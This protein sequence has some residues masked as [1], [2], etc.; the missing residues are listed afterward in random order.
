MDNISSSKN[1]K[2]N[3]LMQ[4][5]LVNISIPNINLIKPIFKEPTQE[6]LK[7]KL[8]PKLTQVWQKWSKQD[9]LADQQLLELIQNENINLHA[10]D[11]VLLSFAVE[12]RPD[13]ALFLI[14]NGANYNAR[15]GAIINKAIKLDRVELLVAIMN[16][17][18]S[19]YLQRQDI[20]DKIKNHNSFSDTLIKLTFQDRVS[21]RNNKE[22]T[23]LY[24]AIDSIKHIIEEMNKNNNLSFFQPIY[25]EI[26]KNFPTN[27]KKIIDDIIFSHYTKTLE[28]NEKKLI[29]SKLIHNSEDIS[30]SFTESLTNN[31]SIETLQKNE[32]KKP[33][34]EIK[35][36]TFETKH[37]SLNKKQ[38]QE[39]WDLFL[40]SAYYENSK[41]TITNLYHDFKLESKISTK[42][43]KKIKL[44]R[45]PVADLESQKTISVQFFVENQLNNIEKILSKHNKSS[46][47]NNWGQFHS[48]IKSNTVRTNFE[49]VFDSINPEDK[50]TKENSSI[51]NID[52]YINTIENMNLKNYY[53]RRK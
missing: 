38:L 35:I 32:T 41:K 47:I 12:K 51:G 13:I 52:K 50:K 34:K 10:E 4:Q 23:R 28:F 40:F 30:N 22:I 6:K 36:E 45:T 2:L 39:K 21:E 5:Y 42:D 44:L 49:A 20:Q 17:E 24:P 16:I 18:D 25:Q 46:F 48:D 1:Q 33:K 19:V 37:G 11:E 7:E 26:S 14:E 3:E 31:S 53:N 8:D 43:F 27:E 29:E 15:N 9:G